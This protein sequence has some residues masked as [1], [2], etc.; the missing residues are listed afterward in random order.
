MFNKIKKLF[1]NEIIAYIIVGGMTT[2][3]SLLSY[4]LL[5][6]L[7]FDVNDPIQLTIANVIS[8]VLAVLFAFVTN[9]RLVFKSKNSPLEEMASFF[10]SRLATLVMDILFMMLFVNIMKMD[11]KLAKLIVQVIVTV[12]NYIISK[13]FVFNEK[14]IN[15]V[16][17]ETPLREKY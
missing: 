15:E 12:A 4:F 2:V 17:T 9:R 14:K 16:K 11:D 7:Y 8:W 1:D 6:Q 3:V 10:T 5:T 13:F